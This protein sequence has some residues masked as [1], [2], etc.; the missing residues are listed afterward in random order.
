[1]YLSLAWLRLKR[2]VSQLVFYRQT[3]MYTYRVHL[4]LF[5]PMDIMFLSSGSQRFYYTPAKAQCPPL[6]IASSDPSQAKTAFACLQD[7]FRAF[8]MVSVDRHGIV[9]PGLLPDD[10]GEAWIVPTTETKLRKHRFIGS[11]LNNV[12]GALQI[13]LCPQD[14]SSSRRLYSDRTKYKKA[15][16][17]PYKGSS[18]TICYQ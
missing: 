17:I 13:V 3:A 18:T 12:K 14:G 16:H 1:M 15:L 7:F 8:E 10:M 9:V 6:V 2:L 4:F 11:L 5:L